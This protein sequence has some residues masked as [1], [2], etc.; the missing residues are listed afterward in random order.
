MPQQNAKKIPKEK[1][2]KTSL[3]PIF[4]SRYAASIALRQPKLCFGAEGKPL[5]VNHK[6]V[7]LRSSPADTPRFI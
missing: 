4:D 2:R 5:R 7:H 3:D 6:N 1:M